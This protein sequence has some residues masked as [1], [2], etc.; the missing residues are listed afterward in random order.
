MA[1]VVFNRITS[2]KGMGAQIETGALYEVEGIFCRLE[3]HPVGLQKAAENGIAHRLR[4][5]APGIRTWPWNVH[6][7]LD[8]HLIAYKF[9]QVMRHHVKVVILR[10][11][12]GLSAS[13]LDYLSDGFGKQLIDRFIA[14][15]PGIPGIFG[16]AGGTRG[17]PKLV[18][19]KPEQRVGDLVVIA[20]VI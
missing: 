5:N 16:D 8:L 18:L 12:N 13:R 17:I 10:Q 19:Y 2:S 9:A 15:L 3:T 7:G 14:S 1:A 6:E 20:F 4:Q 11:D